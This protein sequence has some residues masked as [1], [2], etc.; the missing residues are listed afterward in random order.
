MKSARVVLKALIAAALLS[1][2][3]V[4]GE[5]TPPAKAKAAVS[6]SGDVRV[7]VSGTL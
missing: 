3:G 5:P 6:I 4:D 2:C 1:G 7:G